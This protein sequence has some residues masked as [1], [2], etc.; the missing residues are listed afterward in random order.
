M[1]VRR[2]QGASKA[3]SVPRVLD[4]RCLTILPSLPWCS[5]PLRAIVAASL[6][7]VWLEQETSLLCLLSA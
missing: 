7:G 2:V 6:C 4:Q 1:A 3:S 5:R